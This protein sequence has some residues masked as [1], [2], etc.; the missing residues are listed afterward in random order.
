MGD[1]EMTMLTLENELRCRELLRRGKI[2]LE[3]GT[4]ADG[5]I[6]RLTTDLLALVASIAAQADNDAHENQDPLPVDM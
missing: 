4:V 6:Y 3:A 5:R 1:N 2:V